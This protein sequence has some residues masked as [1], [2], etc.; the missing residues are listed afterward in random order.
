M[1]IIHP[2]LIAKVTLF[3][4]ILIRYFGFGIRK[5]IRLTYRHVPNK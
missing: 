4:L 1:F 5:L 3:N 2:A